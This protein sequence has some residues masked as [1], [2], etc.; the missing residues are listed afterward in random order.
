CDINGLF[1]GYGGE[2][3]KTIIPSFAGAK[4]S[5][6]LAPQQQPS[7][8][9][10]LFEDWVLAHHIPGC[11]WKLTCLGQAN[12]V[13]VSTDSPHLDAARRAIMA[14]AGHEPVLVREGATI[15]IVADFKKT[16][17]TDSLL[18]GFGRTSDRIHAPNEKFDLSCF[19]LGCRTHAMLLAELAK[20]TR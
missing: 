10:S 14:S 8:I 15:P 11:T 6:R 16:L 18:I 17:G 12:P 3:A 5:F 9:G 7:R 4:V 13:L 20:I 19:E 2:G 1:G